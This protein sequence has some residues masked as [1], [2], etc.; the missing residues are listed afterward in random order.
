M[1]ME[2]YSTRPAALGVFSWLEIL[3]GLPFAGDPIRIRLFPLNLPPAFPN[4]PP[5]IGSPAR[6]HVAT[7]AVPAVT[8]TGGAAK[9]KPINYIY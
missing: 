6:A 1:Y 8:A 5:T 2:R 9:T 7:A 3:P 4:A